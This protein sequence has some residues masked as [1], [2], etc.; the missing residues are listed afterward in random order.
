MALK[1]RFAMP[2][3]KHPVWTMVGLGAAAA[4]ALCV[5]VGFSV[6]GY[7]YF[8][9]RS[10]VDARLSQPIFADTAQIYA[11]PREVRPG[12]KLT[13]RLIANELRQ[14]GYTTDGAAQASPL[15][16]YNES[17]QQITVHPGP[18]S[19]HAP[20]SA[21]I[22]VDKGE[23]DTITDANGQDLA[24]YELEPVL[25]TGLSEDANRSK[26]RL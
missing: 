1:I 6:F 11:A 20:D 15:G 7:Y 17:G 4:I 9:Y 21:T 3:G 26:R 12:Q 8:K 19:Y 14:A 24:S 13:V 16:S 18:Q 2:Q 10:I 22:H 23:V 25:I 5:L